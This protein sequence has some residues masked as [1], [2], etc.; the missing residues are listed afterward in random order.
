MT[1]IQTPELSGAMYIAGEAVYG[2]A[3]TFRGEN[4]ADGSV[5]E[6]AYRNAS[7]KLVARA[8]ELAEDAFG[9]Y[10]AAPVEQRARFLE[11]VAG[12]IDAAGSAA[13]QRAHLETGLPMARLT[14]EVARTTGQLRLFAAT[15]REGSWNGARIDH[16]IPDRQP[17]RRPDIR[18]R[19]IPLGPVA[20]FA[21]SNFPLAFSVAGGDTASALAAGCPVV[22]KAH[23]AHP[24]TSEI[25][26]AAVTRAVAAAGLP[27][28]VFSLIYGEGPTAGVELVQHPAIAAVGFTGSRGA[29]LALAAAAAARPVPIPVYAEMSSVNPVF[30]LPGRLAA[31][32]GDIA[33]GFAGSLTLGAGQ[34]CT[35]P[36][37]VFGIDGPDLDRFVAAA[38]EAVGAAAPA[39]MLTRRIASSYRSGSERLADFPGTTVAARAASPAQETWGAA[40]LVATTAEAFVTVPDLQNEVFGATSLVVRVASEEQLL[41]VARSLEGQLTTAVHAESPADEPLAARL[42]PILER[43]AGRI[44]FN[45]WPT[46]VEVVHSMVHGGPFPSTS[47]SRTTSVGTLA[48]DRFLRPVAYQDV[49]DSLLPSAVRDSNPDGSIRLI[50]GTYTRD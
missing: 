38:A 3:E 42:L 1:S 21:A 28:G 50:D 16:A 37:I 9:A 17:A 7:G 13:A 30:L 34:F 46:G 32:A 27:A 15:L 8:A 19:R 33:A 23:E 18:T 26:A 43:K 48:M 31:A 20:V 4:P 47:D 25:V 24:G 36:G 2:D 39:P 40:E 11:L 41:E 49:P 5:L 12:E 6:P 45:G 10:R 29:G 44:L 14:G 22:V 35:N